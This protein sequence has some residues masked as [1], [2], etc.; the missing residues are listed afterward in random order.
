MTNQEMIH[1]HS[2]LSSEAAYAEAEIEHQEELL[3]GFEESARVAEEDIEFQQ[4]ELYNINNEITE[5]ELEW[6][7]S[8]KCHCGLKRIECSCSYKEVK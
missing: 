6:E 2:R 1:Q 8:H 5:V 7:E 4:T 3:E